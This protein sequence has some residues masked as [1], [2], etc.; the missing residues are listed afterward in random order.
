MLYAI[1]SKHAQPAPTY[2]PFPSEVA[3]GT[4]RQYNVFIPKS[5]IIQWNPRCQIT[6]EVE[7][8]LYY[9]TVYMLYILSIYT[10]TLYMV[11]SFYV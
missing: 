3:I 5:L 1:N 8:T 6:V 11:K 2:E 9:V 7:L 4:T 10:Y